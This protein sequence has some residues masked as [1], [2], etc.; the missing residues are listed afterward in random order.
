MNT[1]NEVAILPLVEGQPP[2]GDETPKR[3]LRDVWLTNLSKRVLVLYT[4]GTIGSKPKDPDP[5]SPQIVTTWSDLVASTP[6]LHTLPFPVDCVPFAKP[7]DSCNVGPAEWGKMADIIK[8][9][10]T[11]YEGFVILHGTDTMA[12]TASAL[13]FMLRNLGKPV[14]LTGAQISA[15][16]GVRND[17]T[18]NIITALE[19]ANPVVTGISI[20]PEVCVYFGGI[21]LRGNRTIKKNTSS[22]VPFGSP[23]LPAIADIGQKYVVYEKRLLSSKGREFSPRTRMEPRVI[24]LE[25][26]PGIQET[27]AIKQV[28]V[29]RKGDEP[30]FKGA[31]LRA[32]GTGDLPT[33]P[34]FIQA[35]KEARDDGIVVAVVTQCPE[36][37]VELGI[38]DTSAQLVEAG[39]VAGYD[40]TPQAAHAKLMH[41]LGNVDLSQTEVEEQFQQNLVGEQSRSIWLTKFEGKGQARATGTL[42]PNVDSTSRIRGRPLHG[43]WN[44]AQIVTAS[45]RLRKAKFQCAGKKDGEDDMRL[46]LFVNWEPGSPLTG[47][48]VTARRTLSSQPGLA[49]FELTSIVKSIA[50][51]GQTMSFAVAVE[52]EGAEVSWEGAELALVTTEVES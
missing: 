43:N 8:Q 10:Y 27:E 16:V 22:L 34:A 11:K 21:L 9:H 52:S 41:L 39:L 40:I 2:V 4:G 31:I 48:Y 50:Q 46:R 29:M 49:I 35:L 14:I 44:N 13:S 6:E 3:V 32:Y 15:M 12:N 24:V 36:G 28:L 25:V 30:Y 7:L 19:L 47:P 20:I 42:L 26:N 38:Y 1:S 5:G 18:Q 45:L 17:A 23:N 33:K 51:P 37:P